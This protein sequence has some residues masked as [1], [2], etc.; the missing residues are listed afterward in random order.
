M[1][2]VV[3]DPISMPFTEGN[4]NE[5]LPPKLAVVPLTIN[6]PEVA[7][8]VTLPVPVIPFLKVLAPEFTKVI[9]ALASNSPLKV[10]NVLAPT[11]PILFVILK[12]GM[13][14]ALAFGKKVTPALE[15]ANM[16][17]Y[18]RTAASL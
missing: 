3:E 16:S 13:V 18:S 15:K 17:V 1:V 4:I 11:F 12:T 9:L 8:P 14:E 2:T 5:P 10:V 6:F 7:S